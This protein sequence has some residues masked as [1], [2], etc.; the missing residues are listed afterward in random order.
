MPYE[1]Y[2]KRRDEFL[3]EY[4]KKNLDFL[5]KYTP[6]ASQ[7]LQLDNTPDGGIGHIPLTPEERERRENIGIY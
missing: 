1:I 2:K 3:K 6:V 7:L 5:N 4:S